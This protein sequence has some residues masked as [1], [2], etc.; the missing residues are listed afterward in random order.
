MQWLHKTRHGAENHSDHYYYH[1]HRLKEG[2]QRRCV[3]PRILGV[4]E[5]ALLV[6]LQDAQ[7]HEG[8]EQARYPSRLICK[9]F[10]RVRDV[11]TNFE[12]GE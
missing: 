3:D 1:V 7:C 5:L 2:S 4:S 11:F 8:S 12:S 6:L 10:R 9:P